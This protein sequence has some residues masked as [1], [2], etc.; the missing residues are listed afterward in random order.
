MQQTDLLSSTINDSLVALSSSSHA[1]TVVGSCDASY[2]FE[3]LVQNLIPC[4][5][6]HLLENWPCSSIHGIAAL[7]DS[8]NTKENVKARAAYIMLHGYKVLK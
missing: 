5:F 8:V 3:M 7:L 1:H 4:I 2:V 6:A